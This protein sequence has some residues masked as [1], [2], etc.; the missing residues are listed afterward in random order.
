M[1]FRS[2]GE[3]EHL[4]NQIKRNMSQ[5]VG[6]G[7]ALNIRGYPVPNLKIGTKRPIT[8]IRIRKGANMIGYVLQQEVPEEEVHL[9]F[10]RPSP[11]TVII[12]RDTPQKDNHLTLLRTFFRD[13]IINESRNGLVHVDPTDP[14][15]PTVFW[16]IARRPQDFEPT[17]F[18]HYLNPSD[19]PES[20]RMQHK[21]QYK[22]AS[23][24]IRTWGLEVPP[25]L[26]EYYNLREGYEVDVARLDDYKGKKGNNLLVFSRVNNSDDPKII[27]KLPNPAGVNSPATAYPEKMIELDKFLS[28]AL[29][30]FYLLK[31]ALG[32]GQVLYLMGEGRLGKTR[33][34]LEAFEAACR[35]TMENAKIY[36]LLVFIGER[37][38]DLWE[39]KRILKHLVAQKLCDPTRIEVIEAP[40]GDK[41]KFQWQV[42]E[43]AYRRSLVLGMQYHT[44][45]FYESGSRAVAAHS[46]GGFADP[47]SGMVSKGIY[48]QSIEA[49]ANMVGLGGYYPELDTSNTNFV[50]VLNS[51]K[52]ASALVQ[53]TLETWEHNTTGTWQL[54]ASSQ[55]KHPKVDVDPL[56]TMVRN[57][58]R[59]THKALQDE[60]KFVEQMTH[61]SQIDRTK[62]LPPQVEHALVLTYIEQNPR[63]AYITDK[64]FK[65]GTPQTMWSQLVGISE[66]LKKPISEIMSETQ[67]LFLEAMMRQNGFG[68]HIAV[69]DKK[70]EPVELILM[71][72]SPG[73]Q[74][75]FI[76]SDDTMFAQVLGGDNR[77]R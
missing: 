40:K 31:A 33:I 51:G 29:R 69:L 16:G 71:P 52:T 19:N 57:N 24:D 6:N 77:R 73:D 8:I 65:I 5:K 72:E 38:E 7:M 58:E 66:R 47:S 1:P 26:V 34:T 13:K 2:L 74:L 44:I 67:K 70:G 36:V 22:I 17:P 11:R 54:Y 23:Q 9:Y 35:L 61:Y 53:F 10:K 25:A 45:T 75:T 39:Y 48:N 60:Q 55:I 50:S 18:P 42:F 43:F 76:K 28:V 14:G 59:H 63:P 64:E 46:Y 37:K 15:E 27:R 12:F 62:T 30:F 3:G 32:F 68:G 49:V 41:S 4:N 20:I 21:G 56:N